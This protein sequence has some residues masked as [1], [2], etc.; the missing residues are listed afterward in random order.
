[1]TRT[2]V[3]RVLAAIVLA[4]SF[5]A[6]PSPA[7]TYAASDN[8]TITDNTTSGQAPVSDFI[9]DST[10]TVVN[11]DVQFSDISSGNPTSWAWDFDNNGTIDSTEQ[12]PIY[13]Y[14]AAGTYSVTLTVSNPYG[15]DTKTKTDYIT[16]GAAPAAPDTSATPAVNAPLATSGPLG[17]ISPMS[18]A[19]TNLIPNAPGS[20]T[21]LSRVGASSNWQACVS[22]DSDTSYVYRQANNNNYATDLY[23]L[24]DVASPPSCT[25]ASVTVYIRARATVT[26]TQSSAYID[27]R[28]GGTTY[29][30]STTPFT[31]TTSYATYSYTWFTNPQTTV[32]WTWTDINAL[33]AGSSLR[34][35][36]GSNGPQSRVTAVWVV[37][38]YGPTANFSASPTS[39]CAPVSVIFTDNS[40][41]GPTSWSW[42]FPGGNPSTATVQGPLTIIYSTAGTYDV[43]LTVSNSCG[44]DTKTQTGY[45]TAR[46]TPTV[47]ISGNPNICGGTSTVLTANPSG[48]TM[49]YSYLWYPGGSTAQSIT[50]SVADN[51][52]ATVTDSLGCQGR[53][54]IVVSAKSSPSVTLAGATSFCQ[55]GSTTLTA[56]ASGGTPPYTYSW[57]GTA[58]GTYSGNTYTATGTGSVIVTV[59]DSASCR[60]VVV[61]DTNT[62]VT[63]GN[64]SGASYPYNAV[65]AWVH[66]SWWSGL[67]YNFGYAN[68]AAQWIWESY[69]VMHPIDGDIVYFQRTFS[70]PGSPTGASLFVTADNGYEVSINGHLIG[71]AQ[72]FSGW[73]PGHL[74]DAYVASSGWQS[75]EGWTIPASWLVNGT[76]TLNI[77]GVNEYSGP[78]DGVPNGTVTGNPGAIIYELVWESTS[79]CGCTATDSKTITVN[80]SPTANFIGAPLSGTAPLTVNFTDQSTGSPTSWAWDFNSDNV[81]ESTAQNPSYIYT[82]AGT[83]S[84]KLTVTNSYGCS[85]SFTRTN[86]ITVSPAPTA[87]T[88]NLIEIYDSPLLSNPVSL[89]NPMSPRATY[90]AKVTVTTNGQQLNQLQ[91]VQVTVFY[92]G[93]GSDNMT[94]PTSSNT[95][96]CAIL[97]RTVGGSTWTIDSGSPTT[98]SIVSASCSEPSNLNNTTGDWIFAFIPGKVAQESVSPGD[99]DAQA[100]ATNK[101]ALTGQLYT[102]HK[103][104]NWYGEITVSTPSVSWGSVP[105]GLKF[106]DASNPKTPINITYIA[107]GNY[108]Q[109]IKSDN[110]TSGSE[111]V[112]LDTTGGNPPSSTSQFALKANAVSDNT[113][114][115]TITRSYNHISSTGQ[116][117]GEVGNTVTANTLWLSLSQAGI[118]PVTYQ[119]N[120][121]YQIAP[122]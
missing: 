63:G 3:L 81:T 102:R 106:G 109:D 111:T 34:R 121:Y 10:S 6:A 24:T 42:S 104:M 118:L 2:N 72:L 36:A 32:A 108:Y 85:N 53:A 44:S 93:S 29:S 7:S 26:P 101:S 73:G 51:Y 95:Q 100:K 99:W 103:G 62:Q 20:S 116:I 60:G 90:Y 113:T 9:A 70:V 76:N 4:V 80:P 41:N 31:L 35:P 98:W 69:Y 66:P 71:S 8:Q 117:T 27:I 37:V 79:N 49:P 48:G 91:T 30:N 115:V 47:T 67:S 17:D 54:K 21:G 14:P 75:V 105:L 83:Y 46:P 87:P 1:M 94:A 39:G 52:T 12:N 13:Q 89:S 114:W 82:T 22:D 74:T 57:S 119:G 45:I 61:S 97:S 23:N 107:N 88:V 19:T 56:N 86:Y 96:T 18:T 112:T 77:T 59:T 33:Q 50:A 25:I 58:P 78:L 110:W 16:V 40:T 65:L 55:G 92:N 5:L 43:T 11:T 28:T 38:D 122:R 64:I 120:I 68:N 15:S 84:V